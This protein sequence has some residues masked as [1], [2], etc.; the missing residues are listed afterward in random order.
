MK[1]YSEQDIS[2]AL[3]SIE[4]GTSVRQA[5]LK[6]G[7]PRATLSNRTNGGQSHKTSAQDQQRLTPAQ[8]QDLVQ[9]VTTQ[10]ELGV[11]V[12][13]A[14]VQ[15]FAQRVLALNGDTQ[16]LGKR[17]M[18]RFFERNPSMRTKQ[19]RTQQIRPRGGAPRAKAPTVKAP[20]TSREFRSLLDQLSRTVKSSAAQRLLFRKMQKDFDEKGVRLEKLRREQAR[21]QAELDALRQARS[22]TRDVSPKKSATSEGARKKSKRA[23]T[24]TDAWNGSSKGSGEADCIVVS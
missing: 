21:L 15:E 22:R 23:R 24:N 10:R 12:T 6:F 1:S 13:H 16:P 14:Q 20:M 9:W 17:W 5:S 3:Q 8:E 7:I 19:M 2:D 18:A 11:P 4:N